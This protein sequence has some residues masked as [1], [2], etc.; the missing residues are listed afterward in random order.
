MLIN[1]AAS[2]KDLIGYEV[3]CKV[4]EDVTIAMVRAIVDKELGKDA[5]LIGYCLHNGV[6]DEKTIEKLHDASEEE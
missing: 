5:R 2:E 1:I 3:P 6:N 4:F